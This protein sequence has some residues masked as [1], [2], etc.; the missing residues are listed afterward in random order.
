MSQPPLF[1]GCCHGGVTR[2]LDSWLAEQRLTASGLTPPW[3]ATSITAMTPLPSS[4]GVENITDVSI[5]MYHAAIK[6]IESF[7]QP[8]GTWKQIA[9]VGSHSPA[10]ALQG[11]DP[12]GRGSRYL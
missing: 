4:F 7:L 6:R 10:G 1:T 5:D 11:S 8:D 2:P 9:P 3:W 12:H